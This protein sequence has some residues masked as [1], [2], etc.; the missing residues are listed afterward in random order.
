MSLAREKL[1]Y[2]LKGGTLVCILKEKYLAFKLLFNSRVK[3]RPCSCVMKAI[4]GP[5][6]PFSREPTK[7]VKGAISVVILAH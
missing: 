4:W 6:E 1:R 3:L 5:L 2:L 7:K